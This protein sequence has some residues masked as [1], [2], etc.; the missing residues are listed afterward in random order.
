MPDGYKAIG[1][2]GYSLYKWSF[3]PSDLRSSGFSVIFNCN[4]SSDTAPVGS[5]YILVL[6]VKVI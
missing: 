1:I 3:V 4:S 6:F 5:M 2:V